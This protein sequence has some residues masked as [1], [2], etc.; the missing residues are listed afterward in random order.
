MAKPSL[1]G[2]LDGFTVSLW[3]SVQQNFR[4]YAQ[5]ESWVTEQSE[6]EQQ[7]QELLRQ[8][9]RL[10]G[11]VAII[12]DGN[13]RWAQERGLPRVE[14]HRQGIHSVREVVQVA[15]RLHIPYVTLY[16]F[17]MENWRRPRSEILTLMRLLQYYLWSDLQ[18]LQRHNIRLRA[19]GKLNALPRRVQR[20][21]ARVAHAT[22]HNTG[23]TL[24]L[25]LSYS[26][27]WDIVRAV[28]MAAIDVRR[29]KLSPEDITEERFA[30]YLLTHELPDPDLL[31]R[32]SGEMRLSNF[33]LWESAYAEIY[34]SDVYWPDFRR[35][36]FY[37]ALLD[38]VRRERRFGMTS[39]QL[40]CYPLSDETWA[41]LEDLLHALECI[42]TR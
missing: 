30:S 29:G 1:T 41:Q 6:I 4:S 14:G 7:L 36:A 23:L 3:V 11:H 17:S 28:Q 20:V 34:I 21:L 13:G 26:G 24:T 5:M 9:G 19:I 37:R 18:E 27:R 35:C 31:I 32:T 8:S 42:T 15:V 12:M 2:G 16:A 33:L 22:A 25:A 10:P 39:E 40:G 38:Y